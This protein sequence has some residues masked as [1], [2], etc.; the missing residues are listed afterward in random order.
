M[1]NKINKC[2]IIVFIL[3]IYNTQGQKC[4][5]TVMITLQIHISK[6]TWN[7]TPTRKLKKN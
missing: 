3:S 6:Y 1:N 4:L 2:N 5:I 7:I